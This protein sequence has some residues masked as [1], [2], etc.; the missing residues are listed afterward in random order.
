MD[1]DRT[2]RATHQLPLNHAFTR[3]PE[4]SARAINVARHFIRTLAL[5]CS[6]HVRIRDQIGDSVRRHFYLSPCS[7]IAL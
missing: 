3:Q 6:R 2:V 5:R 7:E 1:A 4:E